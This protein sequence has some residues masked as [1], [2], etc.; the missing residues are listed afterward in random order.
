[1]TIASTVA[2]GRARH[3]LLMLDTVS[4]VRPGEPAFNAATGKNDV[5]ST[6]IYTGP[7]RCV[8]WRGNEMAAAEAEVAVIRYRLALP[9]DGS[10]PVLAR[11]DVATITA[12]LDPALVGAVLVLT[13]PEIATT[14]SAL[15]WVAE[16]VT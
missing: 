9:A 3:L 13:E 16:I 15:R 7:M 14:S 11:R 8:A 10:L 4:I 6:P 5:S 1:M 2:R 12:S